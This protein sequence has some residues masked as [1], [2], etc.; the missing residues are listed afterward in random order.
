MLEKYLN[1]KVVIEEKQFQFSS[2]VVG[3]TVSTGMAALNKIEGI[4]TAIDNEFI[5][6]DNKMIIARKFIY[7][8]K[9]A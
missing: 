4:I 7:R 1:K 3:A 8:I 6:V 2:T 5:E 9:L